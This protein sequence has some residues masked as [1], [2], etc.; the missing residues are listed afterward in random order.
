MNVRFDYEGHLESTL[1]DI[2]PLK[3]IDNML[4]NNTFLEVIIQWLHDGL[5]FVEKG[6]G[7]HA[8]IMLEMRR[9]LYTGVNFMQTVWKKSK[10]T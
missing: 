4:S 6:Y 10:W 2:I 9:C 1:H 8:Q 7:V 5:F 3:C